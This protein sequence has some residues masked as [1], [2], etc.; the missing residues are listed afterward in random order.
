MNRWSV[1][2]WALLFFPF[3]RA[4]AQNISNEGTDFWAVFPTHDPSGTQQGIRYANVR[5][6]VTAKAQSKVTVSCG[7]T[8]IGPVDIPP[9]QAIPF[10]IPRADAYIDY[11]TNQANTVLSQRGIHIVVNEGA[12]VAAYEHIYAGSRSA[13]S[14][15]LPRE[16]LG[17]QYY[18]MNYTQDAARN[19]EV[20]KGF[21]VLVAADD[22]TN[23]LIHRPGSTVPT[24]IHL[25]KAGDVYQYMPA[26]N[27][28][29]TGTFVE[30]DPNS[31]D[32]CN[33]R[34]AA[35]SGS[36]SLSIICNGS[37]DPLFQQLY[38][39]IS[40][41]KNYG[42]VPFFSRSY[43]IRILAQEDNTRVD[44]GGNIITLDKGKY[45]E[46]PSI[47]TEAMYISANKKISV[48][49]YSLTQDC[50]LAGGGRAYGDPEMVLLNP[51]EF[52]IKNITLFSSNDERILEKYINVLIKT[53]A[54]PS[55]T[56][57]G[58]PPPNGIWQ[59]IP[60]N[61]EYSF[62]Q[63]QISDLNST[64]AANEG[65]NAIAYGFGDHES[66]AYS[67]G[68]NLAANT[69]FLVSNKITQR[70]AQNA[71]IGQK[72]DFKIILPYQVEKIT[73]QLD[74]DPTENGNILPRVIT[75]SDGTLSY[76]YTYSK[77]SV[78]LEE[79]QHK[80]S[81]VVKL[82]NDNTNCLDEEAEFN[83]TFDVYPIPT[84]DFAFEPE[85][86]A[87]T[88]IQFNDRGNSN[89][90][91][92]PLNKW[93]WDF[94]DGSPVSTEQNPKHTYTSSGTFTVSLS[95]GLDDGCLSDVLPKTITIKPKINTRFDA[96]AIGC[97]NKEVVFTD[98]S[99]PEAGT[100]IV[101]WYWNFGDN[102]P[103]PAD[104]TMPNAKHTYTTLGKYT[105]SL[106]TEAENGCLSL[107]F[108]KDITITALPTP[109]FTLPEVCTTDASADFIN[110][111]ADVDG[112]KT[113]LTYTWDFGDAVSPLNI[114]TQTMGSHKYPAAGLYHVTLTVTNANG[115]SNSII[116][117]FTVNGSDVQPSF[118]V[119]NKDNLCSSVKV[120]FK[121]TSQV[122]PLGTVTKLRWYFDT[123]NKPTEFIE[124]EDPD[125]NKAYEFLYPAPTDPNQRRVHVKMVAFSGEACFMEKIEEITLYP[126]PRVVFDVIPDVCFNAGKIQLTQ[127][128]E[129]INVPGSGVY[130][131]KGITADGTFDP[132][133]AGL[134]THDITYTFTAGQTSCQDVQ[135]RTITVNPIPELIIDRDIYILA[136]G[137][138]RVT[139]S[140]KGLGLIYKWTPATGLSSDDVLEPVMS[141]DVDRVYTL[142]ISSSQSCVI[143]ERIT[144]HVLPSVHAPNAFSPNGDGVND[145]WVLKYIDTYPNATVD[146]F[147]RYGEK[148]FHS[149][150]YS[151][152]FDGNFKNEALPVGTYYYIIN[153]RNGRKNVTG[154]L[155]LIR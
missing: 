36:T 89:L 97:I 100:A 133:I 2:I 4:N 74:D 47:L 53:S 50:S 125:F 104:A 45:Y 141:G 31:A 39:T 30:I 5:I 122:R 42:I 109:N 70:D 44:I 143:S 12:K 106:I 92:R 121:N 72:S 14:L 134:G 1:I 24:P 10:D 105:V 96:L 56:I 120:K 91:G 33:K 131:G 60:S 18:S 101:K 46:I 126:S 155:T 37:K 61:P 58:L 152:P 54:A 146:V 113:G 75:A 20:S 98:Q 55:F 82:A 118:T 88:D 114:S 81:I 78:F 49:Q 21:L 103:L 112:S 67:A 145:T 107:A 84:P 80:V 11:N 86:C 138:K 76:E 79:K 132:E 63:I 38:P 51:I 3:I 153:P 15:I 23:L 116:K 90:P 144:L 151:S 148:V 124:D 40:W 19:G 111:S 66:Y 13:A 83:Y 32:N 65:F 69:Y 128:R 25:D 135:V 87:D 29:L 139:A 59:V 150:G 142:T 110:T 62:I 130:S 136:G 16:A 127:A 137:E 9:N 27:D 149:V 41:G 52:N 94:G 93:L 17:Q 28:D 68:T 57:N 7:A 99:V 22:N 26:G 108:R 95:V 8:V 85:G 115:C 73:W 123:D 117:D 48:A 129:A 43:L 147:N 102:T 35:F 140:A 6:Y 71:C 154:S 34:F 119:A 64:L 77:G